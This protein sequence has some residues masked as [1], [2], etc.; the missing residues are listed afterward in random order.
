MNQAAKKLSEAHKVL[1]VSHQDPDGD[2]LGSSLGLMHLLRPMGKE[3]WVYN[4]GPMPE[5]YLFLPGLDQVNSEL[6]PSG[7]EDLVALLD[8][9]Q[10]DRAGDLAGAALP[11]MQSSLVIDHHLGELDFGAS[12]WVEPGFAATSQMVELL[13]HESGW[14]MNPRAAACLFV[15][16]QTDTGSFQYSNT[17]EQVFLCAARLVKAGAEPWPI[18]QEVYATRPQRLAILGRIMDGLKYLA[19]GRLVIG[20]VSLNQMSYVDVDSRDLENAVESLRG[21]QGVEVSALVREREEGGVKVS[22][23]ARGQF[24]VSQVALEQ[25]GGGHRNAAGFK[26]PG[27][28]EAVSEI[29]RARIVPVLEAA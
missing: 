20:T 24:D 19:Q 15:G 23:R 5:E 6:P 26:H 22:L 7:W 25:G 11:K 28:L 12:A 1:V 8:C 2:A 10:P 27:T 29:L 16:L 21:I 4:E 18:S 3:V 17:S 9:H 13:A 14:E